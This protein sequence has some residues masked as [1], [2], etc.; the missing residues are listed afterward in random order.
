M[1]FKYNHYVY[2][3][4]MRSVPRPVGVGKFISNNTAAGR[5][6][7]S[8]VVS[9]VAAIREDI[10]PGY[11][12]TTYAPTATFHVFCKLLMG[13]CASVRALPVVLVLQYA[14]AGALP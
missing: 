8:Q 1:I 3:L 11:R 7:L 4:C 12:H 5:I 6:F 9:F 10:Y 14:G 13:F 2:S